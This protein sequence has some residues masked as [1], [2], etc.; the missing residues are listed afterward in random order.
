[1]YFIRSQIE[2]VVVFS[3]EYIF[4]RAVSVFDIWVF[5]LTSVRIV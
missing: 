2:Y 5:V 4:F 1:M 3:L